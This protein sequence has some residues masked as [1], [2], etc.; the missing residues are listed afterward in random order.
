MT[1][2]N[3][4]PRLRKRQAKEGRRLVGTRLRL[5]AQLCPLVMGGREKVLSPLPPVALSLPPCTPATEGTKGPCPRPLG[6]QRAKDMG[7][8]PSLGTHTHA[9]H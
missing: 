2:R 7:S 8:L 1:G 6:L 5:P 9:W 3:N 4:K